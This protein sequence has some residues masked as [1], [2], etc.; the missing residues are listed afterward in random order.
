MKRVGYLPEERGLYRSMSAR[1]A[2]A[3]LA[4]LKGTPASIAFKRADQL[5]KHVTHDDL[6]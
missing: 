1:S 2:I 5:L 6:L 4:R 3:Y